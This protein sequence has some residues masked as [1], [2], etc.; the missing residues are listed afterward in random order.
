MRVAGAITFMVND[1]DL[2]LK[3]ARHLHET[4]LV[5]V[6]MYDSEIVLWNKKEKSRI[7]DV[8]MDNLRFAG[9]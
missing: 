7:K 1:R 2:Q 8:Q 9:Y 4:F 6:L 3:C 5:P